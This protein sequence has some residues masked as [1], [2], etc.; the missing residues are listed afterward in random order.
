MLPNNELTSVIIFHKEQTF[1]IYNGSLLMV[2][3]VKKRHFPIPDIQTAHLIQYHCY[4]NHNQPLR[5]NLKDSCSDLSHAHKDTCIKFLYYN[6]RT[7]LSQVFSF[8]RF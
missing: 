4:V 8:I 5:A 2:N 6:N 3:K 7:L 1:K